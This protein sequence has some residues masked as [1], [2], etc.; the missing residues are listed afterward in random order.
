MFHRTTG[1]GGL[2]DEFRRLEDELDQLFNGRPLGIRSAMR[3]T[4]PPVNVGVT[5]DEVDVYVYAAGIDPNNVNLTLH[6]SVLTIEGARQLEPP[7][8]ARHYRNERFSGP[9]RRAISLPEDIDPDRVDAN[10][11]DGVLRIR[12]HRR[13]ENRPRK[14]TV[15]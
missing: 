11:R 5:P 2:R 6:S 14:I 15:Q 10:Y 13:E 9:F 1:Y 12:L 8:E 7:G 4:Y 3:G